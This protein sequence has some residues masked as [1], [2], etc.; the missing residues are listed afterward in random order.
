LIRARLRHAQRHTTVG[1]ADEKSGVRNVPHLSRLFSQRV[2]CSPSE[3]HRSPNRQRPCCALSL[4][5][6]KGGSQ[7]SLRAST[8]EITQEPTRVGVGNLLTPEKRFGTRR[9]E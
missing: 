6:E 9:F 2:G 1:E 5:R 7:K 4:L 8:R 3:S